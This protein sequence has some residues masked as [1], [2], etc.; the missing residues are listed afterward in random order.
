MGIVSSPAFVLKTDKYRET[1]KI[2]TLF[3]WLHGKIRCIAKGV[4]MTNTKWGGCLQSMAYLNVFY[5]YKENRSLYLLSNAEYIETYKN[6]QTDNE[7]LRIAY[8]IAEL[9][10]RTTLEHHDNN[11]IFEL[12]AGSLKCLDNATKNYVNVL[13]KCEIE[14]HALPHLRAARGGGHGQ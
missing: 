5:Y 7:K 10:N 3:T 1:S 6:L 2:V 9:I 12:L 8:Q 4:R 14:L 11:Q 13:F